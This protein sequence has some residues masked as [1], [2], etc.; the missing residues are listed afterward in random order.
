MNSEKDLLHQPHPIQPKPPCSFK[1]LKPLTIFAAV[2]FIA[3]AAG[4]AGYLLGMRNTKSILPSQSTPSPQVAVITK[5]PPRVA[6]PSLS[7][8][9]TSSSEP[10]STATWR[11]Y[12]DEDQKYSIK[13]PASWYVSPSIIGGSLGNKTVI[14]PASELDPNGEILAEEEAGIVIGLVGIDKSSNEN[15]VSYAKR[16]FPTLDPSGKNHKH[17]FISSMPD[18]VYTL[19]DKSNK[20]RF[21]TPVYLINND[22]LVY[23]IGV[24]VK[25]VSYKGEVDQ[26]LSTFK[27]TQ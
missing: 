20:V 17:T 11:A 5:T 26:I 19:S 15:L 10:V 12:S 7:P 21:E 4:A 25:N 6:R 18:I 2:F 16:K 27:F 8:L 1:S 14:L 3:V 13:Y 9:P 23:W 24:Q 22:N